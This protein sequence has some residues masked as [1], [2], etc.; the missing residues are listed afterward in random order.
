LTNDR[1]AAAYLAGRDA[2]R[3]AGREAERVVGGVCEQDYAPAGVSEF[4]ALRAALQSLS[5][6]WSARRNV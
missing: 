2:L 3:L 1:A 5:T 4:D 6:L